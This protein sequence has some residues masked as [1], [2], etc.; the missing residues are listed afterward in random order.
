MPL[1]LRKINKDRWYSVPW[2]KNKAS[3]DALCNLQTTGNTLSVW[4]IEDDLSNLLQVVAAIVT[5]WKE[6][7]E[8]DYALIDQDLLTN[9]SAKIEPTIGE[10]HYK[11]ANDFWHRD[12]VELSAEKLAG[13]ANIIMQNGKRERLYERQVI[14]IVKKEVTQGIIDINNLKGKLKSTI[15]AELN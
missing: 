15:A 3:A 11:Q 4:H 2:L 9:I 14:D 6:P 10:T 12:I 13:L 7:A 1:L 5:T 8:F